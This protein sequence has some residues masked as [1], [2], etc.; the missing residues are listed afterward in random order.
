MAFERYTADGD[1]FFRLPMTSSTGC[2]TSD[3]EK[4]QVLL[5]PLKGDEKTLRFTAD[6][7]QLRLESPGRPGTVY[8][9]S[10][11]G[12]WYDIDNIDFHPPTEQP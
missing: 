6:A 5:A 1:L 2:Y 7:A 4:H 10:P 9:L 11:L 8:D 3:P 12:A